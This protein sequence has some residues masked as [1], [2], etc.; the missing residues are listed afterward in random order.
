MYE[1]MELVYAAEAYTVFLHAAVSFIDNRRRKPVHTY[2]P[3]I[4]RDPFQ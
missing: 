3:Q 2:V 1:K 4:G